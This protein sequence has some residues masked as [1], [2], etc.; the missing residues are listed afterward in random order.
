ME[1]KQLQGKKEVFE[2]ICEQ[3]GKKAVK[4]SKTFETEL[5]LYDNIYGHE[6]TS[7]A[8]LKE[9]DPSAINAALKNI[10]STDIR[11]AAQKLEIFISNPEL[12]KEDFV[13]SLTEQDIP[14][15]VFATEV[16][17]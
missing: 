4:D 5:E 12:T 9:A 6:F 7:K 11:E 2:N 13:R 8:G 15:T 1:N 3:I 10:P 14:V 17:R 16:I